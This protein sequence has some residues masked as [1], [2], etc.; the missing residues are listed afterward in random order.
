M[1]AKIYFRRELNHRYRVVATTLALVGKIY[2][3]LLYKIF[4]R[5]QALLVWQGF[6][7][8]L[9]LL[10]CLRVPNEV[11]LDLVLCFYLRGRLL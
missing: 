4:N 10:N 3:G 1:P 6:G 11:M 7:S 5:V 2:F 9:I 8:K